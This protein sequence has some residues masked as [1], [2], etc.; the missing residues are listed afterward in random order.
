MAMKLIKENIEYEQLLGEET[1]DI[2]IKEEYVVPDIQP[3]VKSILMLDSQPKITNREVMHDKVYLEGQIKYNVLYMANTDEDSEAYNAIYTKSFSTYIEMRGVQ[4]DMKCT[5][6]CY[7]EHMEC[8][9]INERKVAVEGIIKL[10]SSIYKK[11]EIEAVKDV[12]DIDDIQFLK[13]PSSV[14]K[15]VGVVNG[16]LVSKSHMQV[17]MDKP[18]IGKILKCNVTIHKKE[19]KLLEGKIQIEAFT[20]VE[21]CYKA[22]N[23]RE[24]YKIE[25]DVFISDEVEFEGIDYF[26]DNNTEFVIE[27]VEYDVKDNDLGER[28]IVDVESL[29]KTETRVM[30]KAEVDMIEDAYSPTKL[31]EMDKTNYELNVMLGQNTYETIVKENIELNN[32]NIRATEVVLCCGKTCVTDKKI[33]EDKVVIEGLARVDVIYK[34]DDKEEYIGIASQE[35]PFNC[36]VDI[37]GAKIDMSCM[38]KIYLENLEAFVEANTIAVKGIIKAY[39]SVNY[40]TNKEFLVDIVPSEDNVINKKASITIYVVQDGDTL[41]KIAKKY[42]TTVDDLVK[43]NEIENEDNIMVGEKLII[44]GRAVI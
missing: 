16:E 11:Y 29:I 23:S 33:V 7:I 22:Q 4:A 12:E 42:C 27:D 6:E 9:I 14:D 18:E 13:N 34:T 8:N 30:Y 19:V 3:D 36:T 41:W 26:M 15:I 35:I 25:D 40:S 44:P 32:K 24:L 43:I 17:S 5:A 37:P 28:R 10:K 31:L 2:V 39:A 1:M 20:R 38:V 21:V